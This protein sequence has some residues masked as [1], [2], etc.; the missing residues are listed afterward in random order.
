MPV[1]CRETIEATKSR[2]ISH[3]WHMLCRKLERKFEVPANMEK[4]LHAGMGVNVPTVKAKTSAKLASVIEG[5]TSARARPIRSSSCKLRSCRFKALTIMHMLSTPT[6]QQWS[7]NKQIELMFQ[8]LK[9]QRVVYYV[10]IPLKYTK[11]Y[12]VLY[13]LF[14]CKKILR[15]RK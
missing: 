9:F 10:I 12:L 13:V 7:K 11:S 14:S 6:C 3:Q 15:R 8:H 1:A 4:T 2:L 5:P